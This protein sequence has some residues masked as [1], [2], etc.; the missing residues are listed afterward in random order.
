[1]LAHFSLSC[2]G[3]TNNSIADILDT[4]IISGRDQMVNLQDFARMLQK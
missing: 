1:M 4:P 2:L 3:G